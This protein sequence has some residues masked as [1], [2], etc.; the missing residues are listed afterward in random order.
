MRVNLP[1]PNSQKAHLLG[2]REEMAR[3]LYSIFL[4]FYRY[5]VKKKKEK[6]HRKQRISDMYFTEFANV[7]GI[8]G[9]SSRERKNNTGKVLRIFAFLSQLLGKSLGHLC[10]TSPGGSRIA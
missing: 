7:T 10:P 5:F 9:C 3:E 1:G 8:I 4:G 6:E 2:L